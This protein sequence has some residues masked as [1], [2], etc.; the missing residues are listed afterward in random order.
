M[1]ISPQGA[2]LKD[3]MSTLEPYRIVLADDHT[4]FREGLKSVLKQKDDMTIIGEAGDGLELLNTLDKLALNKLA[5][6]LVILDISMPNLTGIEATRRIKELYPEMKVMI[7]SMH[8]NEE[9][10]HRVKSAGAEGYVLKGN[11]VQEL[12]SAIEII[13]QGGNYFSSFHPGNFNR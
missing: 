8:D 7:L 3:M 10:L 9:Y 5:P 2:G 12:F 13:R 1:S 6:H 11:S 4:L